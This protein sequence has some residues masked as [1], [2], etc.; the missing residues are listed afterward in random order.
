MKILHTE[1]SCGWGGQEIRILDEAEGLARRG[2]DL[3]IVAPPESRLYPEAQKRGLAVRALPIVRKGFTGWR[4]LRILLKAETVDLVNTHSSTDSWLVAL[5]CIG[6]KNA[7]AVMRTRHIS[8]P[9][10]N[11]FLTRW[12][13]NRA[14]DHVITTGEVLRR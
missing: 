3:L 8:A 7:P 10:P 11:N 1:S 6:L 2:H 9:I 4:A 12:L 5:A 14:A 13:Y